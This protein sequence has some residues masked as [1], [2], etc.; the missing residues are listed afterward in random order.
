[1]NNSA[2]QTYLQLENLKPGRKDLQIYHAV[3]ITVA[4]T[5][6]IAN[7]SLCLIHAC[8]KRMQRTC[9]IFLVTH[10]IANTVQTLTTIVG[11]A[12]QSSLGNTLLC[13]LNISLSCSVLCIPMISLITLSKTLWV[14]RYTAFFSGNLPFLL[15]TVLLFI[16]VG[17]A[18]PPFLGW[19]TPML[20]FE[21]PAGVSTSYSV[22]IGI[23]LIVVPLVIIC[24]TNYKLF[25]RVRNYEQRSRRHSTELQGRVQFDSRRREGEAKWIML[26]QV[27]AFVICLIPITIGNILASFSPQIIPED[28]TYSFNCLAQAYCLISPLLHGF[29]NREVR[30]AFKCCC[31]Q[32]TFVLQG[33]RMKSATRR[34]QM[35]EGRYRPGT[36]N[37][38]FVVPQAC[39]EQSCDDLAGAQELYCGEAARERAVRFTGVSVLPLN[40]SGL[41]DDSSRPQKPVTREKR[42]ITT[43]VSPIR[44]HST[45]RENDYAPRR[46]AEDS[47]KVRFDDEYTDKQ[48]KK[49][50]A[51]PSIKRMRRIKRCMSL[52][53]LETSIA[54]LNGSEFDSQQHMAPHFTNFSDPMRSAG[55][56]QV[57]TGK[58]KRPRASSLH[59]DE[60]YKPN[61]K[62]FMERRCS[63]EADYSMRSGS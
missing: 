46:Q 17:V 57:L 36:G 21:H 1:M 22:F 38:V 43:E 16:S 7:F 63:T 20:F 18:V 60:K 62:A 25:E 53:D 41:D 23:L 51:T 4:V 19:G 50:I 48:R 3:Y 29:T 9:I 40:F 32:K 8:C 37:R 55:F 33:P 24:L 2:N 12:W 11:L 15:L 49:Y 58:G 56:R 13:V 28:V 14:T 26:L 47:T 6:F 54:S 35:G 5:A 31:Y 30:Q 52:D 44:R 34:M 59:R 42:P 10:C 61:T 39:A 27:V 45:K